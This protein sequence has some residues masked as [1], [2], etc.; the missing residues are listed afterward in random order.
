MRGTTVAARQVRVR[1][2]FMQAN[3][4]RQSQTDTAMQERETGVNIQGRLSLV[5]EDRCLFPMQVDSRTV[6]DTLSFS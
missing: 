6:R 5:V 2:A 1:E 4:D 3:T